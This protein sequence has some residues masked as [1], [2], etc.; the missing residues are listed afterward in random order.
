MDDC[1]VWIED[2]AAT[3]AGRD[4][5]PLRRTWLSAVQSA[6]R[7]AGRIDSNSRQRSASVRRVSGVMGAVRTVMARA[8]SSGRGVKSSGA[9]RRMGRWRWNW[10][11]ARLWR[12][13]M[14]VKP[15]PAIKFQEM[16]DRG[17]VRDYAEIARL[18]YVTRARIT[19]ITNL[20]NLAPEFQ[21]QLLSAACDASGLCLFAERHRRHVLSAVHWSEQRARFRTVQALDTHN[22]SNQNCF[23]YA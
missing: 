2:F 23:E 8:A 13:S 3:T 20:L 9:V 16:I 21:G 14:K 7:T 10:T 19:Q 17:E 4:S 18:G 15:A 12:D 22:R 1:G 6:A 11:G 5:A